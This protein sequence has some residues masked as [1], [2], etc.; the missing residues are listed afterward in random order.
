MESQ[1]LPVAV[2]AEPAPSKRPGWRLRILLACNVLFAA[3]FAISR[4]EPDQAKKYN[5]RNES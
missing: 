5:D 4:L 3:L 1:D 2:T